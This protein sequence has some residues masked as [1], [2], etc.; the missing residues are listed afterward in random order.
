MVSVL[1]CLDRNITR[2]ELQVRAGYCFDATA[3]ASRGDCRIGRKE[4]ATRTGNGV[5]LDAATLRHFALGR[6]IKPTDTAELDRIA[7]IGR[8]AAIGIGGRD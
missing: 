7:N 5:R 4:E 2:P 8:H 6:Y 3:N 1:L